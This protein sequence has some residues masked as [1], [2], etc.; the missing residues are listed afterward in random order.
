MVTNFRDYC[1]KRTQFK[2]EFS[3]A[4]KKLNFVAVLLFHVDMNRDNR[5]ICHNPGTHSMPQC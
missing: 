1:V 4:E 2:L 5:D 3:C